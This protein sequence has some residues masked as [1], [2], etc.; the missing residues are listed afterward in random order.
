MT[1]INNIKYYPLF[2]SL[3]MIGKRSVLNQHSLVDKEIIIFIAFIDYVYSFVNFLMCIE[4]SFL[5][6]FS[7]VTFYLKIFHVAHFTSAQ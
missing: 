2:E 3:P 4:F 1:D 6:T 5:K 7:K